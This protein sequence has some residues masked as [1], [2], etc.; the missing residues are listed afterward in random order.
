MSNWC[1]W[2]RERYLV[3]KFLRKDNLIDIRA[4]VFIPGL[5]KMVAVMK[6]YY[7]FNPYSKW[8]RLINPNKEQ[9]SA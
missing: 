7:G 6:C 1:N 8:D 2:R 9:K 5:L 3:M 4:R